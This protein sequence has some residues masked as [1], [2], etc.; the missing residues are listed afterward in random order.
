[1]PAAYAGKQRDDSAVRQHGGMQE[2]AE[3]VLR[4]MLGPMRTLS[5]LETF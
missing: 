5:E 1:M 4:R 2:T 3:D